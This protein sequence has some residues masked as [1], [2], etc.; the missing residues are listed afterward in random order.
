[1]HTA[2]WNTNF[3][4]KGKVE[5]DEHSLNFT[6]DSKCKEK[7]DKNSNFFIFHC[8]YCDFKCNKEMVLKQHLE[9]HSQ[10]KLK[11]LQCSYCNYKCKH[12]SKFTRHLRIHTK[13]TKEK[14]Y[15]CAICDYKCSRKG[16]L[17]QHLEIHSEGK[18]F[19]CIYCDYKCNYKNN[20]T[21]HLHIHRALNNKKY[22]NLQW[23]AQ[24]QSWRV[25]FASTGYSCAALD[26][27]ISPTAQLR[28]ICGCEIRFNHLDKQNRHIQII[29]V[30]ILND[31]NKY[32]VK[33]GQQDKKKSL[34]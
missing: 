32:V 25:P 23:G 22:R 4:D 16:N 1:M 31:R 27:G 15:Q 3:A 28:K 14:P 18:S 8:P 19:H 9:I 7:Q 26:S 13:G 34:L 21:R 5:C 30:T 17:T 11:P 10:E 20:F 2:N 6:C 12:K 29:V 33:H 24:C